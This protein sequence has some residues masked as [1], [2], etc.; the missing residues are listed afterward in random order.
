ML[1]A[2][3]P[4]ASLEWR[5]V[6]E[7]RKKKEKNAIAKTVKRKVGCNGGESSGQE[8]DF[9]DVQKVIQSLTKESILPHIVDMIVQKEDTERFDESF[10]VYLE[11][12]HYLFAHS[13]AIDHRQTKASKAL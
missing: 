9:L 10:T 13:K 2:V 3:A 4:S 8:Q 5:E 11:L 7:K 6:I 12:G 1:D